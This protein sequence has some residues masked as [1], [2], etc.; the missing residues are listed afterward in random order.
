M[1]SL[2]AGR[3]G[4]ESRWKAR[5]SAR[6]ETGPGTHP[7]WVPDF[8]PGVKRDG[9]VALTIHPHP[10]PRLKKEKSYTSSVLLGLRGLL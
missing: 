7:Y 3:P 8:I 2:R 9:G 10:A 1:R 6:V 5:F 4:I